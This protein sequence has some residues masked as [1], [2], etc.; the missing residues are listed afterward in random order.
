VGVEYR[1]KNGN[2]TARRAGTVQQITVARPGDT[3]SEGVEQPTPRIE[4][5]RDDGQRM[6]VEPDGLY[7]VGSHAPYV[8]SVVRLTTSTTSTVETP[9]GDK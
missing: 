9:E 6:H 4:F 2:G 5:Q 1:K 3:W 8:G 7:T